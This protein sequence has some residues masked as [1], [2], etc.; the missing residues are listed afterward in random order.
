[1]QKFYS[2]DPSAMTVKEVKP[3]RYNKMDKFAAKIESDI[4][5]IVNAAINTIK[6]LE[7]GF[8]KRK[9]LL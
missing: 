8:T 7:S 9:Q 5:I 4:D 3:L 2:K 6:T 1:M